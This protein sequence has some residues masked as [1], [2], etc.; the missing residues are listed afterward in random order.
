MTANEHHEDEIG[1][2]ISAGHQEFGY[3]NCPEDVISTGENI[4]AEEE[5]LTPNRSCLLTG[6]S[7]LRQNSF[8]TG[9]SCR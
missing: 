4:P 5:E 6:L 8:P 2:D 3:T 7:R 1:I 9:Y